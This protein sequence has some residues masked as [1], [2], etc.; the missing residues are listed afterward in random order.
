MQIYEKQIQCPKCK[1]FINI[2][3]ALYTQVL[4]EANLEIQKQ[5]QE[6]NKEVE[7]KRLEYKK[8]LAKLEEEK[9]K[10]EEIIKQKIQEGLKNQIEEIKQTAQKEQDAFKEQFIQTF[11]KEHEKEK[12]LMQNELEKKSK[13]LSELLF[14]KAENEQLKREQKE[15]EE[16]IKFLAKQEAFR[17]FKEQEK[18][19][20]EFEKERLR[21]EFE[22]KRNE[23]ELKHQEL[24]LQLESIKKELDAAKRKAEQ[25]SQQ[26][27][28]EAQ[29]L[30]IEEFL[31]NE[32][33]T[34]E[35]KEVPKGIN[36][37]DCIHIVKDLF[38]NICGSI[39]YESK[40]TKEF[41]KEWLDKLKQDSIKTKV[42]LAILLT[43]TMPKDQQKIHFKEGILIC[44]FN[45]FKSAICVIRE[46]I[47]NFHKLKNSLENKEEKNHLLYEYLNSK[48]FSTQMTLILK[49]YQNMK[50]DL[51]SEMRAMQNI[52]KKRARAIES[53]S[54]NSH[55]IVSSLNAIFGTLR[56]KNLI[57]E[58]GLKSL[59]NLANKEDID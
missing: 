42:D 49:T 29:E 3:Q 31:K 37:A 30:L 23:E 41:N 1:E 28:G 33:L 40:R 10:Q 2:N 50:E 4:N 21:L 57:G 38:G 51:E 15:N 14:L 9:I 59:E 36:G 43:K 44:T 12:Q 6:F 56:G 8:H 7:E 45:E 16:K 19:N 34:D 46:S 25:G 22:H 5:K 11:I 27:Q 17:E 39:L 18:K 47:I 24:K 54:F 53:L 32:F 48:E 55:S 20:L 13:E 52:W 26:L 58:D 35:I